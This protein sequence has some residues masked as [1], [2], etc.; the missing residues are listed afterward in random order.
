MRIRHYFGSNGQDSSANRQRQNE[1][2]SNKND[3]EFD[4]QKSPMSSTINDL[5]KVLDIIEFISNEE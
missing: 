4:P 5:L 1:E 2:L 3:N